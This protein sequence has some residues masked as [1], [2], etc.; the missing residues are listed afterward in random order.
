[1]N[2]LLP[3]A[4]LVAGILFLPTCTKEIPHA[5]RIIRL[6]HHMC[7]SWATIDSYENAVVTFHCKNG[8]KHVLLSR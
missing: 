4:F 1:M 8:E 6:A 7:R 2:R 3:A 5:G